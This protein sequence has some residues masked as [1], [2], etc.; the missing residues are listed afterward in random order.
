MEVWKE[1]RERYAGGNAPRVHQLKSELCECKQKKDQSVV[2]YYT[3]LIT[4]WDELASYSKVP[5]CTCGTASEILKEREEEKV[6]QFLM[7]LD[8]S[9][10]GDIRSNLLMDD[11]I[12]SLSRAYALVLRE[13]RHKAVTK[14]K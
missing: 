4:I 10:Y 13:E 2:Q 8:T 9:L 3:N 5:P 12:T 6:H 7:G 1:L 11:E 14:G